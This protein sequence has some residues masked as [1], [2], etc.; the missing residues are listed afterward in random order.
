MTPV[1]RCTIRLQPNK[2]S[3][4]LCLCGSLESGSLKSASSCLQVEA[5]L[6]PVGP[7]KSH[8]CPAPLKRRVREKMCG[9]PQETPLTFSCSPRDPH[10]PQRPSCPVLGAWAH[11]WL[12][13]AAVP[14]RFMEPLRPKASGGPGPGIALPGG[15]QALGSLGEDLAGTPAHVVLSS[16]RALL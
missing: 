6:I 9:S 15:R 8:G 12:C 14:Q 13:Q 11:G 3:L 4:R 16:Q 5:T 7:G 2:F 1:Y 10:S